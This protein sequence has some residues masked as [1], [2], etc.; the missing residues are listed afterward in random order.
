MTR[1]IQIAGMRFLSAAAL[2]VPLLAVAC[3]SQDT[4][5]SGGQASGDAAVAVAETGTGAGKSP[6]AP[7]TAP[8]AAR[9]HLAR[10]DLNRKDMAAARAAVKLGPAFYPG[11]SETEATPDNGSDCTTFNPDLSRFTITG[12]ARSAMESEGGARIDYS[13]KIYANAAQARRAFKI[14]TGPRDL[15]C[16]RDGVA[17]DLREAG[18]TLPVIEARQLHEPA[19]GTET[20]IYALY[21]ELEL[22]GV[23]ERQPYPIEVFAF[24]T[25]R[26][27]TAAFFTFIADKDAELRHVFRLAA[28]VRGI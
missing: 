25:G 11:W 3:G 17:G 2:V 1:A 14:T 8:S 24:R 13:V 9:K 4:S 21:Y 7:R 20:I 18:F 22:S 6:P 27:V 5:T 12:K 19:V 23:D 15:R 10:E 16:I 28:R 26:V